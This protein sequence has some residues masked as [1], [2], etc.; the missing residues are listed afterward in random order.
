MVMAPICPSR[1]YAEFEDQSRWLAR[2]MIPEAK[3]IKSAG[4]W[5]TEN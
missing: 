5:R 3:K 1:T 2:D 4:Q